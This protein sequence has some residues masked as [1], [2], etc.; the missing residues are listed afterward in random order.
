LKSERI[1]WARQYLT[2][3]KRYVK[4]RAAASP[5]PARQLGSRAAALKLDPL[6]LALIHKEALAS[7]ALPGAS[8]VARR[9]SL[10]R[11]KRFFAETVVPIEKPRPTAL[12]TTRS[13]NRLTRSLRKRS[14]EVEKASRLLKQGISRRR[15]AEAT[16][17][18]SDNRRNELLKKSNHLQNRL[19]NQVSRIMT[20]QEK[21][22]SLDSRQLQDEIAQTLLA[23]NI[24]LLGLKNSAQISTDKLEKEIVE[25]QRLVRQ[26]VKMIQR[27]ARKFGGTK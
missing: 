18:K 11:A 12:K 17:K 20:V 8:P 24:R 10:A 4:T 6:D 1:S 9:K 16:L 27:A 14:V 5:G 23:I 19:R 13:L 3:L 21:K 15:S 7:L 25:T 2:A 26:S 22:R